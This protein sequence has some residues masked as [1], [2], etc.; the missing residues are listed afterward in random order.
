MNARTDAG[1]TPNDDEMRGTIPEAVI[2]GVVLAKD[3]AL[4]ARC[5]GE[6][7]SVA[8]SSE[9]GLVCDLVCCRKAGTKA[10]GSMR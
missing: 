9:R 4:V 3:P 1:P 5:E 6:D 10:A 8:W 7:S 2:G